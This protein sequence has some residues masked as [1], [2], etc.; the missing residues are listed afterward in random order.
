MIRTLVCT[1]LVGVG[2]LAS[3]AKGHNLWVT[4][5]HNPDGKDT[6]NVYFEHAPKPGDGRYNDP[7]VARG[8]T[9]VRTAADGEATAVTLEQVGEEGRRHLRG[10]TETSP[11][12]S[13]EHSCEWGIY[14]G[15]LDYF[16]GKH[17]DVASR[18]QLEKLARAPR[19]PI[20]IVPHVEG[21]RLRLQVL[22]QGKPFAKTGVHVWAPDGK[23]FSLTTDEEGVVSF[24]PR[25]VGQY[26]VRAGHTD[27]GL[28]GSY[29]GS[30]YR[31]VMHATTLT[32]SWPVGKNK[33]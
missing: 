17:L 31:G 25:A 14:R 16:H 30:E 21:E 18:E 27:A 7:I 15:Q 23:E 33:P 28:S 19:L 12:R 5:A 4:V 3:H 22:W 10:F 32:L 29:A 13:V 8:R 1:L 26:A 20:D 2:F 11:P 9:W 6:V 24:Q